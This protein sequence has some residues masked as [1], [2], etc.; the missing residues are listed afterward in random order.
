MKA[1]SPELTA[2]VALAAGLGVADALDPTRGGSAVV[3]PVLPLN[4][5]Q[6]RAAETIARRA[7]RASKDAM[8][9]PPV[10]P[11]ARWRGLPFPEARRDILAALDTLTGDTLT[12]AATWFYVTGRTDRAI[13]SAVRAAA[14]KWPGPAGPGVRVAP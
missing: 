11:G 6:R 14:A 2:A 1:P 12:V 10:D 3:P 7:L 5:H 4:R 13:R 9:G 8:N